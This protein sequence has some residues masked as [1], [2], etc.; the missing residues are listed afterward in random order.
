[1]SLYEGELEMSVVK[2]TKNLNHS[3]ILGNIGVSLWVIESFWLV[4][5]SGT[6]WVDLL[7]DG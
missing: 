2:S 3:Y 7:G 6:S 4:D 5:T 1:M